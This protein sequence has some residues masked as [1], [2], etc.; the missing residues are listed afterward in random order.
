MVL[1]ALVVLLLPVIG[2]RLLDRESE[3]VSV[4]GDVTLTPGNRMIYVVDG[5]V[6]SLA[7]SDTGLATRAA[8][9]V[10]ELLC[11]R[12]HASAGTGL[13]LRRNNAVSWS[14]TVL[15]R[16]LEA[17]STWPL[18]GQPALARVSPSGRMAAWTALEKGRSFSGGFSAV[19][20]IVDT[21]DGTL[22]E[23]LEA[24]SVRRDGR[25]L[26]GHQVWGVTFADNDRFYATVSVGSRTWL[27]VGSVGKRQLRTV[28][29]DV[30]LP[31][32]APDGRRLAVVHEGRL[33]LFNP[34]TR[35]LTDLGE[36][37]RVADQPVWL[38]AR[39]VAYVLRDDAGRSSI[40][41]LQPGSGQRPELLV[42]GA[43]SPSPLLGSA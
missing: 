33:A 2:L 29:G 31:A 3:T 35:K 21:A 19:T 42:D 41:S 24:F 26:K 15:D 39:T 38:D 4:T 36:Q 11:A 25:T 9:V 7:R 5:H 16:D 14:A 1:I 34:G 37:R 43:E 10:S 30:S 20:S 18:V 8:P 22:V 6:A 23:D 12:V 28:R 13:C 27:A 40:W 32:V 17:T